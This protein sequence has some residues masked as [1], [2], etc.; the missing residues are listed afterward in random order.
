MCTLT[1]W[2][3]HARRSKEGITSWRSRASSP[4]SNP[5]NAC[6]VETMGSR[7][8]RRWRGDPAQ[9]GAAAGCRAVRV[10]L[11]VVLG[12]RRCRP[13]ELKLLTESHALGDGRFIL[14]VEGGRPVGSAIVA[15]R[16]AGLEDLVAAVG[17][18]LVVGDLL[19]LPDDSIVQPFHLALT[20]DTE[21]RRLP[22]RAGRAEDRAFG[23][24]VGERKL[25]L[26][27]C[28]L[29]VNQPAPGAGQRMVDL[30]LESG[31]GAFDLRAAQR[32]QQAAVD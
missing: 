9:V 3:G 17:R 30:D 22:G 8:G 4:C 20:I 32:V 5:R 12:Q 28:A 15:W 13:P 19:S 23:F 24:D 1:G 18:D 7:I 27:E 11:Q 16:D 26:L 6:R 21:Q 25:C 10:E 31:S 2:S 29:K 14:G